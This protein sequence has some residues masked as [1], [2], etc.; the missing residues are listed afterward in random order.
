MAISYGG[1]G[2]VIGHEISVM[3]LKMNNDLFYF[4]LLY[5]HTKQ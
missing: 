5:I 3:N 1:I 4:Y 2:V